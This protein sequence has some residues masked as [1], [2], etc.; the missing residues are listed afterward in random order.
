E[1]AL[2]RVK[3][4]GNW[5]P[6]VAQADGQVWVVAKVC[7]SFIESCNR[8][9]ANHDLHP[10]YASGISRHLNDLCEYCGA[11]PVTDLRKGHILHWVESHA[12]WRSS[13]TRRNVITNVLA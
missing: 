7:S 8:R 9:A 12:T 2:A 4:S 11:M 10:D 1:L 3:S 6:N 13:A 5:R